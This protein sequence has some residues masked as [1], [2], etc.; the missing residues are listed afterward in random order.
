MDIHEM[1]RRQREFDE[2]HETTFAWSQPITAED[3]A[4]LSHNA[5]SLAGEVGELANIVKKYERGDYGFDRLQ[6]LLP[7][8]LAD[9]FIYVLK[10]SYQSGIDLEVAFLNKLEHNKSR[11]ATSSREKELPNDLTDD[12][13]GVDGWRD[14]SADKLASDV[15]HW[16]S[17]A[18]PSSP[19]LQEIQKLAAESG[20]PSVDPARAVAAALLAAVLADSAVLQNQPQAREAVWDRIA[21]VAD[22]YQLTRTDLARLSRFDNEFLALLRSG[23]Q[24]RRG[25]A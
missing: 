3:A 20:I 11:F 23:L 19:E 9:V 25:Q 16:I 10:I 17:V 18:D 12:F 15:S 8:E 4:A 14:R 6:E 1:I 21:P 22:R 7:G 5:L 2:S 13:E 24:M